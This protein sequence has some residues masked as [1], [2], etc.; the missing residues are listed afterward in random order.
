MIHHLEHVVYVHAVSLTLHIY[1]NKN[2]YHCY[3]INDLLREVMEFIPVR[4]YE[5]K[6]TTCSAAGPKDSYYQNS[7]VHKCFSNTIF[8]L[9]V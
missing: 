4:I 7:G 1:K 9:G 8:M 3:S 5:H 6:Y 2:D